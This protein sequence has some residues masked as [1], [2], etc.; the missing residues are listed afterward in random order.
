LAPGPAWPICTRPLPP[1]WPGAASLCRQD[2]RICDTWLCPENPLA[3]DFGGEKA[4]SSTGCGRYR[5]HLLG[6][7][8]LT[9][10]PAGYPAVPWPKLGS[11]LLIAHSWF[12]YWAGWDRFPA[13]FG[14]EGGFYGGQGVVATCLSLPQTR[15][16]EDPGCP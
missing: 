13:S 16:G 5:N 3:G 2:S 1:D 10:V 14:V 15:I 11:L 8:F 7:L 12:P 6:F 9:Q 4:S